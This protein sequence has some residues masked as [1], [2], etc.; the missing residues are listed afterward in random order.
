MSRGAPQHRW[1]EGFLDFYYTSQILK[2]FQ[3]FEGKSFLQYIPVIIAPKLEIRGK[4]CVPWVVFLFYH[5][6]R[7]RKF[8]HLRPHGFGRLCP[9]AIFLRPSFAGL[10]RAVQTPCGI[11]SISWNLYGSSPQIC[12]D[13]VDRSMTFWSTS[14]LITVNIDSR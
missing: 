13:V 5:W 11:A 2:K 6:T 3:T 4:H 14:W 7:W 9:K 10:F 8:H 12:A 1:F